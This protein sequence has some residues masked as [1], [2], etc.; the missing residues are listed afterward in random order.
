MAVAGEN[1]KYSFDPETR[2]FDMEF[3]ALADIQLPSVIFVPR[4]V[5]GM[6]MEV[7]VSDNL[8]YKMSRDNDQILEISLKDT[9]VSDR[10]EKSWVVLGKSGEI[11][12]VRTSST[13]L[14]TFWSFIPFFRK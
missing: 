10:R 14:Q 4:H 13:W 2:M 5:Y 8:S 6:D 11:N 3:D 9:E 12:T 7:I 1:I